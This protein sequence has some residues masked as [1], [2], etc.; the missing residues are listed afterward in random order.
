YPA[1]A[2]W[3]YIGFNMKN[4]LLKDVRVRQALA[5]AMDRKKFVDAIRQGHA[6]PLNSIFASASW[7][8]SD[9]VP[10]YD[11]DVAKAKQLLDAAGWR[12]PAGDPNGTRTKD[13]KPLKMRIFYN[14][15]NQEREKLATIAQ[16]YAKAVGVELEVI[17]EEWNAYLNRV[18]KTHDMEMYILGW[19]A[20]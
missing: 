16:Q 12:A 14:A 5:Q 6:R 20:G 15:G 7:A 2:S 10:K 19:S 11:F 1:S 4:D 13:G 8:Y 3:V 17:S 18:N 9:D